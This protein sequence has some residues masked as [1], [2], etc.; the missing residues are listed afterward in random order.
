MIKTLSGDKKH[1]K[2]L[3]AKKYTEVL[4]NEKNI[5]LIL[6]FCLYIFFVQNF[7]IILLFINLSKE[8]KIN[9]ET[10]VNQ[11]KADHI[12]ICIFFLYLFF[13]MSSTILDDGL[14]FSLWC[15]DALIL[16]LLSND[17]EMG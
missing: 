14:V 6:T 17:I 16:K 11:L 10:F 3:L 1:L 9:M 12:N 15:D 13:W 8:N 4:S 7:E 5:K 2:F